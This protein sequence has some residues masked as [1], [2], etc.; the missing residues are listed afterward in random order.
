MRSVIGFASLVVSDAVTTVQMAV[1]KGGDL[2]L[3]R[4]DEEYE[5]CPT[6]VG[7]SSSNIAAQPKDCR[8][9]DDK[10]S[11]EKVGPSFDK[12]YCW[13]KDP[14]CEKETCPRVASERQAVCKSNNEMAGSEANSAPCVCNS[15]L[16]TEREKTDICGQGANEEKKFCYANADAKKFGNILQQSCQQYGKCKAQDQKL[17]KFYEGITDFD[18]CHCNGI[19]C[20]KDQYCLGSGAH[21]DNNKGFCSSDPYCVEHPTQKITVQ[22]ATGFRTLTPDQENQE[23]QDGTVEI[24]AVGKYYYEF[25]GLTACRDFPKPNND[26]C[27]QCKNG[28]PASS[29]DGCADVADD[30]DNC[31]SCYS[32]Y[33]LTG[34]KCAKAVCKKPAAGCKTVA[35]DNGCVVNDAEA[36]QEADKGYSLL[37][38]TWQVNRNVVK[39]MCRCSNGKPVDAGDEKCVHM[40]QEVCKACQAGFELKDN[41]CKRPKEGS[42][43][44][45]DTADAPPAENSISFAGASKAGVKCDAH[46]QCRSGKCGKDG[47]ATKKKGEACT[48]EDQYQC[49]SGKCNADKKTCE[50]DGVCT[51]PDKYADC[52]SGESAKSEKGCKTCNT[53]YEKSSGAAPTCKLYQCAC[54]NG[55]KFTNDF[56]ILCGGSD[57][58]SCYKCH[59]RTY[60]QESAPGGA[61]WAGFVKRECKPNVCTCDNGAKVDDKDCIYNGAN[62]CQSCTGKAFLLEQKQQFWTPGTINLE[63]TGQ[64]CTNNCAQLGGGCQGTDGGSDDNAKNGIVPNQWDESNGKCCQT[65]TPARQNNKCYAGAFTKEGQG[66]VK[67]GFLEKDDKGNE[68]YVL[69]SQI[70][71]DKVKSCQSE[72]QLARMRYVLNKARLGVGEACTEAR[73][74]RSNVCDAGKCKA[75][76]GG[77]APKAD[78]NGACD[79]DE[80]CK[81]GLF[82]NTDKC[83]AAIDNGAA[84]NSAITSPR[85]CKSGKVCP[86]ANG[87]PGVE[88][89]KC[90]AP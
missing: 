69:N 7:D 57:Q 49:F 43:A 78:V 72:E 32:G 15:G 16:N 75:A 82:C 44:N 61:P 46:N 47:R 53:G 56:A 13:E 31:E 86:T 9:G 29:K 2:S 54:T 11:G 14:D 63:Y 5:V 42:N 37:Q 21:N 52:V 65:G 50:G 79:A 55:D 19:V 3:A 68:K 23:N 66:L 36:C 27:G 64:Q 70:G 33:I 90:S 39:N 51:G 1:S 84:C 87:G 4:A 83:A 88:K 60:F 71:S 34:K 28:V 38:P 24:C 80:K 85:Q 73:A 22:C 81:D 76:G 48:V 59:G 67:V 18:K 35:T 25:M 17:E 41:L 58:Q 74:C 26:H 20:N 30:A 12:G 40:N 62:M 6:K 8:C 10:D 89:D 45:G 77:G